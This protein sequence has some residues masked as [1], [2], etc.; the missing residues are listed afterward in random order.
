MTMKAVRMIALA[1]GSALLAAA[2][3]MPAQAANSYVINGTGVIVS[4]T[5]QAFTKQGCSSSVVTSPVNGADAV[6]IDVASRANSF[7]NFSWSSPADNPLAGLNVY[8]YTAGCQ[9]TAS[10]TD[11]QMF[12][13]SKTFFVPGNAKWAVVESFFVPAVTVT[14]S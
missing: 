9:V 5:H 14:V 7:R 4:G 13:K 1:G 6:I 2:A 10:N 3:T 12:V 8:F 11:P